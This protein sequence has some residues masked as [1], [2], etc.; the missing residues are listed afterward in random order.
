MCHSIKKYGWDKHQFEIL[1]QCDEL[2][3]NSLEIYYIELF[4]TCDSTYGLNLMSGGGHSKHSDETRKEMSESHKGN[5]GGKGNKGT[6]CSDELKKKLSLM[7]KGKK[8]PAEWVRKQQES[9]KGYVTS[10]ETKIKMSIAGKNKIVTEEAKKNMSE[11]KKGKKRSPF[12]EEWRQRLS[13]AGKGRKFTEEHKRKIGLARKGHVCS[14]ETRQK[15][16]IT[17]LGKKYKKTHD[18]ELPLS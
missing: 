8:H 18:P 6:P 9:R 2:E 5:Q 4:Q 14:E 12:S 11:G 13:D 10:D 1:V 15:Q 17:M 16:R 3:L 7:F